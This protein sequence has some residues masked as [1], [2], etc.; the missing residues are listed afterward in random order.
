MRHT[1]PHYT[2]AAGLWGRGKNGEKERKNVGAI[3]GIE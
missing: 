3:E 1:T 2:T